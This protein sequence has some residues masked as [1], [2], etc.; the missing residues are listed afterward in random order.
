MCHETNSLFEDNI[1]TYPKF[2][3][4][5]HT[6][7]IKISKISKDVSNMAKRWKN[8]END[9]KIEKDR[10]VKNGGDKIMTNLHI[11]I[12]IFKKDKMKRWQKDK[13]RITRGLKDE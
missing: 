4:A 3:D 5:S 13:K 11:Q 2:S 8:D 9:E 10:K 7:S 12:E 6:A 1:I